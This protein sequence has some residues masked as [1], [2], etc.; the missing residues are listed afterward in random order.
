MLAPAVIVVMLSCALGGCGRVATVGADRTLQLALTEYRLNPRSVR[1]GAGMLTI[2]VHNYGRLTH[3]L[4]ISAGGQPSVSTKPI[5]PGQSVELILTLI[6]GTYRM[7]S[8]ILSDEALG[9]YGT[10]TVTPSA[11]RA[12]VAPTPLARTM[13]AGLGRR[14]VPRGESIRRSRRRR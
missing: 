10:L 5:P 11:A 8:T 4:V 6:P 13:P 7:A 1:A 14:T 12:A 9:E 3:N 2:R